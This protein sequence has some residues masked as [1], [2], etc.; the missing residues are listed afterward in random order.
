M[1][2]V[3][4]TWLEKKKSI[5]QVYNSGLEY[6]FLTENYEM[7]HQLVYCKDFMQDAIAG[8]LNNKT[9]SIYGFTYNPSTNLPIYLKKTRL[10]ITNYGQKTFPNRIN[11]SKDFLN[12]VEKKL[13]MVRTQIYKD[14]NVPKNY[15]ASGAF[16][17]DGSSR[18]MISPPMISLYTLLIRISLVHNLKTDF[19]DTI[20]GVCNGTITPLQTD[21]SNQMSKALKAFNWILDQNDKNLFSKKQIENYSVKDKE[22]PVS[23]MHNDLGIVS[24]AYGT[25]KN[26][27]PQWYKGIK[28]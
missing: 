19:M 18:W 15:S 27:F 4:V 8:L 28:V 6:A 11:A 22:I 10:L 13:K 16:I 2:E 26:Y 7:I 17:Y 1:K 9:M 14:V 21:D 5:S 12:Q 20:N 3:K 23:T 24:Y 25:P